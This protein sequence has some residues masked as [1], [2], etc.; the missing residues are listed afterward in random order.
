MPAAPVGTLIGALPR[1]TPG[2]ADIIVETVFLALDFVTVGLRL[3]SRHLQRT[4]LQINDILIIAALTILSAR[5]A[6]EV[7]LVLKCGLGLHVDEVAE[8]GGPD[9][10]VL[11][12]K[13]VYAIDL[14]WL[15]LV[16]LIKASILHFY[17]VIFRQT[18]FVRM[19]YVV[20][21]LAIAFWI[22][23]FFSDA[24]FCTPPEKA[25]LPDTPGHCG[26]NSTIYIA[27]ASTDLTIDIIVI[28]LP[29]PVLWGLQLPTPKKVALT[30]V[31]GLGFIIIA[32]T[33]VRIRF[34]SNLD[35]LDITFTFSE[36]ALL[37][38]LVPLLG[39]LNANLP[40]LAPAFKRIFHSSLLSST[41]KKSDNTGSSSNKFQRLN[42]PELPLVNM[43]AS[44]NRHNA[45]DGTGHI[46]VTTDWEVHSIPASDVRINGR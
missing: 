22:A 31:F 45:S 32:I 11:F 24:F 20:L 10:V 7:S 15:T 21:G 13:L 43:N 23:A 12:R 37:S 35:P 46:S 39:I 1:N 28:L 2:K 41:M 44:Y 34:F 26:D 27:L 29:M 38:S 42:E 17:L 30:F 14:M 19:V 36:I 40:V 33:S 9:M 25:W 4:R 5:Y 8:I 18:A 6:I 16:T 3:W